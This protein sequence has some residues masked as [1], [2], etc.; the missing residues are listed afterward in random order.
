MEN[1]EVIHETA[2]FLIVNKPVGLIVERNPFEHPTVE[3]LVGDYLSKYRRKPTVGV[4]H[5]LDRVTSGVM[6]FSK[7]REALRELN[8]YF[9]HK[10]VKKTYVALISNP[11]PEKEGTLTHLLWKDQ[12]NKRSEVVTKIDKGVSECILDYKVLEEKNGT[13]LI[14][15]TPKTGKFHQIRVQLAAV[16]CP[17]IGDEKYGSMI[18]YKPLSICLHAQKL[19]FPDFETTKMLC[20]E[21]EKPEVWNEINLSDA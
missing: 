20:F 8:R 18:E 4:V 21:I 6:V 9:E 7:K 2:N 5:R 15:I 17:I 11:L 19:C 16:G 12:K 14:E 13:Y 1:I 10:E 3:S